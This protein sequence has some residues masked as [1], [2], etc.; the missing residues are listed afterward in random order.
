MVNL[1]TGALVGKEVG[2]DGVSIRNLSIHAAQAERRE[3]L[4]VRLAA[5]PATQL[6]GLA[7][8]SLVVVTS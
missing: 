4:P 6:A 1:V 5:A 3:Q 8:P 2:R 7:G